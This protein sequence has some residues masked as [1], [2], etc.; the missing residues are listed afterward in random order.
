[1]YGVITGII[2]LGYAIKNENLTAFLSSV[3][4]SNSVAHLSF[5][6]FEIPDVTHLDPNV[7]KT[8]FLIAQ[9]FNKWQTHNFV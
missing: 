3:Q 9:S 6:S 8:F 7:S 1:M 2:G 5:E 4:L